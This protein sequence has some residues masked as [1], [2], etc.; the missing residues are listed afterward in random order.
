MRLFCRKIFGPVEKRTHRDQSAV[1]VRHDRYAF[2]I[3]FQM[4]QHEIELGRFCLE[5]WQVPMERCFE[6]VKDEIVVPIEAR[7][8]KQDL[9]LAPGADVIAGEPVNENDYVLGLKDLVPQMQEGALVM[10]LLAKPSF[11][12]QPKPAQ[13]RRIRDECALRQLVIVVREPSA[14][15]PP[16]RPESDQ[17]D[18]HQQDIPIS[19]A[20]PSIGADATA[21]L[22]AVRSIINLRATCRTFHGSFSSNSSDVVSPK[23]LPKHCACS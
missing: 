16:E 23:Q 22:A 5:R 3:L 9:R 8:V 6:T 17:R 2:V 11:I 10:R 4:R 12:R 19:P 7:I 1:A 14:D 20:K 13:C 21:L 15:I 18:R